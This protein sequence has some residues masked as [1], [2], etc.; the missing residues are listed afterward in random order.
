MRPIIQSALSLCPFAP[1]VVEGLMKL[2]PSVRSLLE[3]MMIL[4]VTA[5]RPSF[6][7]FVSEVTFFHR[8]GIYKPKTPYSCFLKSVFT[9]CGWLKGVSPV[10]SSYAQNHRASACFVSASSLKL[11][12]ILLPDVDEVS[13]PQRIVFTIL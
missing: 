9:S 10:P 11:N 2:G 5:D 6:I 8:Y 12:T 13:L 4:L 1:A 3:L 7:Y